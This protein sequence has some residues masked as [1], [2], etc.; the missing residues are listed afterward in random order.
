M[1]GRKLKKSKQT[2]KPP[3]LPQ[4][5]VSA[6]PHLP[7]L[8]CLSF[9]SPSPLL[10]PQ[11][12]SLETRVFPTSLFQVPIP[13]PMSNPAAYFAQVFPN[14]AFESGLNTACE[15][16]EHHVS[17]MYTLKLLVPPY[18]LGVGVRLRQTFRS[19]F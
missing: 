8:C 19:F 3:I 12:P 9:P 4:S 15:L 17:E 1:V 16:S 5:L 14:P 6:S 11:H 7:V 2:R 18:W 10:H 13:L